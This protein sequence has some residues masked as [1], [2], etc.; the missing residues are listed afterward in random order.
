M[1]ST[2]AGWYRKEIGQARSGTGTA[3]FG[4]ITGP[5]RCRRHRNHHPDVAPRSL[6]MVRRVFVLAAL[7]AA[8]P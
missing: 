3:M 4:P 1:T 8:T 6:A 7:N 5:R 2:P